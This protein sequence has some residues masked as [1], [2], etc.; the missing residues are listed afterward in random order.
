MLR[1]TVLG[2]HSPYPAPGGATPGYLLETTEHKI[3]V[4]CGSGVLSQ[5]GKKIA[6]HELDA[7]W[8]SHLHHD[9]ITDLFVLQYAVMMAM[10]TGQREEPLTVYAPSEP[11]GW[12]EKIPYRHFV[13]HQP[14]Q[15]GESYSLGD[16]TIILHRTEHA[17][18][19]YALEVR[20]GERVLLYGADAGPSTSWESMG[21]SPDL[22]ICEGTYLHRDLPP[23]PVG[24]HSVL[25]AAQAADR[26]QARRLLITHLYP[27]YDS[28][29][30]RAEASS[31]YKGEMWVAQS[32]WTIRL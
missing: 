28:D 32:G 21:S 19:C 13:R 20:Q 8:L 2:C 11:A 24:H 30:L 4:D 10:Q 27:E 14:I 15:E 29:D 25:Q 6:P 12:A 26:I 16:V 31:A 23:H 18:P 17:V 9:H 22:F 3:L 5:L 1:W 7:V